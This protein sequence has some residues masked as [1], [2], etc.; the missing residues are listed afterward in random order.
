MRP[1]RDPMSMPQAMRL[2]RVLVIGALAA[3]WLQFAGLPVE[4]Q[5]IFVPDDGFYYLNV[6]ANRAAIGIWSFDHGI[7]RTTGFHL[8]HA[9]V[10]AL[11]APLFSIERTQLLLSVHTLLAYALTAMAALILG[12]LA[13]RAFGPAAL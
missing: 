8:L 4:E 9:Q 3:A 2:F 7:S 12:R 11:L 1:I 5:V 13:A 6:G 10:C